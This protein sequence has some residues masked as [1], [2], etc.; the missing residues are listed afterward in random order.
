MPDSDRKAANEAIKET[1]AKRESLSRS[2]D[3]WDRQ[4][5][6]LEDEIAEALA[7]QER[8]AAFSEPSEQ[9]RPD[10]EEAVETETAGRYAALQTAEGTPPIEN[11]SKFVPQGASLETP[12]PD[13][14]ARLSDRAGGDAITATIGATETE[15]VTESQAPVETDIQAAIRE[16]RAGF[17]GR[18]E[19]WK[20]AKAEDMERKLA[21]EQRKAELER[22]AR[23][24][25]Q[26]RGGYSR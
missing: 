10:G 16:G 25:E 18:F 8:E 23:A 24:K 22:E 9:A 12:V 2:L 1:N 15:A 6:E 4:L 7:G 3:E 20:K 17:R 26:G 14:K 11:T 5:S 19:A 21:D 13:E